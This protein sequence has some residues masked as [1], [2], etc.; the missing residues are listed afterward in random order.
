M[1]IIGF[2]AEDV[3]TTSFTGGGNAP[4]VSGSGDIQIP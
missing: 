1:E 4:D 3:I 2:D